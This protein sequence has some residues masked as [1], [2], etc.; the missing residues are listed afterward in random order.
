MAGAG[1]LDQRVTI[2]RVSDTPDGGGGL[3]RGWVSIATVWAGVAS[4]AVGEREVEGRQTAVFVAMFTI[5][6]R[7]DI[8]ETDRLVWGGETYNIRG[9]HRE[10]ARPRYLRVDAERGVAT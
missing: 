7:S 3:V 8:R 5:R 2:E 10:G 9:I 1:S 6:N 4:R